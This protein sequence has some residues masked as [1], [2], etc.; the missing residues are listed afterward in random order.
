MQPPQG[1]YLH[2][3][4]SPPLLSSKVRGQG[5]AAGSSCNLLLDGYLTLQ[6]LKSQLLSRTQGVVYWVWVWWRVGTCCRGPPA[7]QLRTFT[8]L[9]WALRGQ[10]AS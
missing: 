4:P 7:Y 6:G 1:I 2:L 3:A 5:Q 9:Q 8:R 10:L